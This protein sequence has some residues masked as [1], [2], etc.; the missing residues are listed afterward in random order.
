MQWTLEM[1]LVRSRLVEVPKSYARLVLHILLTLWITQ[2]NTKVREKKG[3]LGFVLKPYK[4]EVIPLAIDIDAGLHFSKR[5][6]GKGDPY[7]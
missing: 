6:I 5:G 7:L 3:N 2:D 4:Q 1:F